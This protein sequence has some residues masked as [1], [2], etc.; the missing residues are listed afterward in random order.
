MTER[1]IDEPGYLRAILDANL[2][3]KEFIEDGSVTLL[4]RPC[5]DVLRCLRQRNSGKD[6]LKTVYPDMHP[7]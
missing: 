5:G 4:Q 3:A 2:A 1:L 7:S 6:C